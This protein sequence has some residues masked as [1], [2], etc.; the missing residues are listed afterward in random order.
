MVDCFM[1]CEMRLGCGTRVMKEMIMQLGTGGLIVEMTHTSSYEGKLD[2][3]DLG[4]YQALGTTH[5]SGTCIQAQTIFTLSLSLSQ[6]VS[7]FAYNIM[8]RQPK[9]AILCVCFTWRSKMSKSTKQW[10]SYFQFQ[11]TPMAQQHEN[12]LWI[13]AHSW[14]GREWLVAMR[15]GPYE[16]VTSLHC[17][18]GSA[19][20]HTYIHTYVQAYAHVCTMCKVHIDRYL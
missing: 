6:P 2:L 16:E 5:S 8:P 17:M 20:R 13:T 1:E 4:C 15:L 14:K 9:L 18:Q 11:W 19:C 3:K 7:T 10:V 12:K